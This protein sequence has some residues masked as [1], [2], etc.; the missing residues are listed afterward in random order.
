M[1][2]SELLVNSVPE[3]GAASNPGNA[4]AI[5]RGVMVDIRKALDDIQTPG[6]FSAIGG[7]AE[8]RFADRLGLH[9]EGVGDIAMPLQE[10]QARQLI[11]Q[12]RQAPYGKGSEAPVDTSVR[13]TW[14]LDASQLEFRSAAWAKTLDHCVEFTAKSLGISSPIVAELYKMLIYEKGAMF[15]AHTDNTSTEKIPG[16]FG[17]L[18]ICLPLPHTGGDLVVRHRGL[19]KTLQ[20][21]VTQ[22]SVLCWYSDV[23]H[24]VLP[25][26]SGYRWVLT[27]NLAISPDLVR[28]TAALLQ[29]DTGKLQQSLGRWLEHVGTQS[30]ESEKAKRDVPH[31]YYLLAHEYS[32]ASIALRALKT[33]DLARLQH[34]E[35]DED[36]DGPGARHEL[37]HVYE[38][39]VS[40]K[41]LVD[42]DGSLLRSALDIDDHDLLDN[43]ISDCVD[44]L[45]G[46]DDRN[47][48]YQGYMGNSGS[49]ATHWYRTAATVLVPR[50]STEK[51]LTRDLDSRGAQSMLR[52]YAAKCLDPKSAQR[53][54]AEE[55]MHRLASRAWEPDSRGWS[56][57]SPD[58][59]TVIEVL[60]AAIASGGYD[61]FNNV[62]AWAGTD[63]VLAR[64]FTLVRNLAL[65]GRLDVSEVKKSMLDSLSKRHVANW[66]DYLELLCPSEKESSADLDE[67][68]AEIVNQAVK[69]LEGD[70]KSGILQENDGFAFMLMIQRRQDYDLFKTCVLPDL[71]ASTSTAPFVLGAL[72]VLDTCTS[73]SKSFP[74]AET[75]EIV[76][77]LSKSV[78]STM[79]ITKL[80]TKQ[81]LQAEE[82]R[83]HG[84]KT[85][86]TQLA[87]VIDPA[88]LAELFQISFEHAW[89]DLLMALSLKIAAQAPSILASEFNFLWIP[90]LE[91][92]I[93]F[94]HSSP[95]T[96]TTPP[97]PR[98]KQL[99]L[100]LLE[101]YLTSSVGREPAP[102]AS[103]TLPAVHC[104]SGACSDCPGLNGFLESPDRRTARF[105]VGKARRTHLQ[106]VLGSLGGMVTLATEQGGRSE[107]LVVTK[108][109]G[110]SQ[111]HRR[112]T[113]L[114]DLDEEGGLRWVIG[115]EE[116][117]RILGMGFLRRG[118][119][120]LGAAVTAGVAGVKRS[121]EE[122]GMGGY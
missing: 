56:K 101:S 74:Q 1:N 75:L 107:T 53:Q 92:L 77:S 5:P 90:F 59:G 98:Y 24:E 12:C 51:F 50:S 10:E 68:A 30:E 35:D 62:V 29:P 28:P 48:E 26:T 47:E 72:Q 46:V 120:V 63:A 103:L 57:C 82:R 73:D 95:T 111:R 122:A 60:K 21:S 102:S 49:T 7:L 44:P 64:T 96:T 91:H 87:Q 8:H 67:M 23:H 117:E 38:T 118:G 39:S 109:G 37:D 34:D 97:S 84:H 55:Y 112:A 18:V 6:S 108:V 22:P 19:Q 11:A 105:Q 3:T 80:R 65:A 78:I 36:E 114:E 66:S 76:K 25:V 33:T 54:P 15:K 58:V 85:P 89:D 40:I 94:L 41:K 115:E 70:L 104:S 16:M 20:T 106:R 110:K 31:L 83:T 88:T 17:T 2:V 43:L 9:V 81:T 4:G 69:R 71:E 32:E 99:T 79:D 86:P 14:E 13:N 27:Y 93:G 121:A 119:E 52:Y 116:Y 45:K 100:S 42:L 61:L 113:R